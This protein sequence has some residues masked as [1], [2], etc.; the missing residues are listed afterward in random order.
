[1]RGDLPLA[2]ERFVEA[3]L[4]AEEVGDPWVVAVGRHNLANVSRDL[5]D[6]GPAASDFRVALAAY[7]E[8][9]DRWSVAHVLEDVAV[10][11]LLG[12][13]RCDADAAYLLGAAERL[14]EEIGAPR[15]PPTEAAID[16]ALQPA[17]RRTSPAVLDQ[18]A[19]DGVKADLDDV[20]GRAEEV[21]AR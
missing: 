5:G 21:L 1:V 4:L 14:R 18:A 10:W 13:Q 2:R 19:A 17:R 3:Q 6:L 15:F 8:R 9:D 7:V 16:E 12:D 20:V 11:R